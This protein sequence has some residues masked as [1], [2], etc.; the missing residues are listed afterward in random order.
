MIKNKSIMKNTTS[1]IFRNLTFK[2]IA[3]SLLTLLISQP[4]MAAKFKCWVN[5]DG[6]K[7]CGTYVPP[8]YSQKRVET[9]GESG[10]VVEVK[11][12]A[13]NAEELA[14]EARQAELKKIEDAKIAEQKKLDSVL[15][16]TFTRERD[17][18]MLRDSKINVIEGIINVTTANNKALTKKLALLHKQAANVERTGKKPPETLLSDI[19]AIEDRIKANDESIKEKH[20]EQEVIRKKFAE[21]MQRFRFLK[22][23]N[24]ANT[25]VKSKP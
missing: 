24:N 12:R 23:P 10:R 18:D 15:L 5:K 14:E 22:N 9:R 3:L 8:E 1:A 21:D 6:V 19:K 11:E 2:L 16:K 25:D 13:K 4:V 20:A 7:E 17:I